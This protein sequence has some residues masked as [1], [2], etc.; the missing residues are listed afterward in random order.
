MELRAAI[1][2]SSSFS[3]RSGPR[4]RTSITSAHPD[5]GAREAD[6]GRLVPRE[7][8]KGGEHRRAFHRQTWVDV[9]KQ[10]TAVPQQGHM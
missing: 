2:E 9:N 8:I 6:N 7:F 10:G 4:K 3:K 1:L 5:E